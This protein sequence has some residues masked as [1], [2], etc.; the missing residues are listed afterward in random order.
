MLSLHTNSPTK[1]LG[2]KIKGRGTGTLA[3][4][5]S[6][7]SLAL[8]KAGKGSFKPL[9]IVLEQALYKRNGH[10]KTLFPMVEL[11]VFVLI[12]ECVHSDWWQRRKSWLLLILL[13]LFFSHITSFT[14]VFGLTVTRHSAVLLLLMRRQVKLKSMPP[15][16]FTGLETAASALSTS[17]TNPVS[18]SCRSTVSSCRLTCWWWEEDKLKKSRWK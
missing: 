7:L 15:T 12:Y 3:C 9:R 2:G 16:A 6:F 1:G 14:Q 17:R 5:F 13:G 8:F 4:F 11:C 10:I 18:S